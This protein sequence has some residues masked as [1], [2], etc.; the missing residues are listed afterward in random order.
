[1]RMRYPIFL[2]LFIISIFSYRQSFSQTTQPPPSSLMIELMEFP[3]KA[4][5]TD[6][7][8][9]FS[10]VINSNIKNE[11]QTAYQILV[12]NSSEKLKK[13][14]GDMWDSGKVYSLQSINVEYK[15]K[16]LKQYSTYFWKVRT[17][18]SQHTASQYSTLQLFKTGKQTKSYQT[19]RYPLEKREIPPQEII[20]AEKGNYFIDF[21]K[22][23]F[24]TVELTVT[25]SS[26][27]HTM[28][29]HLGEALKNEN[30]VDRNPEGN[31]RYRKIKLKLEKGTH[32]YTVSIPPDERNTRERAIK[33][34]DYIGEVMPFRYCEIVGCPSEL[35]ESS[36]A[37][38]GELSL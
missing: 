20:K 29:I 36:I 18:N 22:A 19:D 11:V 6:F 17:W 32:T 9:E 35:T 12:A 13:N 37:D 5:I 33:M 28:E 3:A 21:G 31:I 8:P 7:S 25:S 16:K 10:W 26:K 23:A 34:P 27:K 38:C 15:G 24:G 2:F 14:I 30:S 4:V 1:M